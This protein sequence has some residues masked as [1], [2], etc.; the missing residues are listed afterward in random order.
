MLGEIQF[1]EDRETE[2]VPYRWKESKGEDGTNMKKEA[3]FLRCTLLNGSA[4]STEEKYMKSI[5][6]YFAQ[7][8]DVEYREKYM[9][10]HKGKCDIFFGIGHRLSKEKMEEQFN[11]E[12]KKGGYLQRMQRES[13]MKQQAVRIV[14]TRRVESLL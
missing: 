13:L 1:K 6:V 8:V 10:R 4:K 2:S 11:R 14:S 7:R 3:R 12:T 9:R 5:E